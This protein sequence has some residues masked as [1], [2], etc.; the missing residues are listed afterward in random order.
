M[1]AWSTMD[2]KFAALVNKVE[3]Q[4][5][6]QVFIPQIIYIQLRKAPT[7]TTQKNNTFDF[8]TIGQHDFK[9]RDH[10]TRVNNSSSQSKL[11]CSC[12]LLI[13]V[14]RQLNLTETTVLWP[15]VWFVRCLKGLNGPVWWKFTAQIWCACT[16]RLDQLLHFLAHAIW[17]WCHKML[18]YS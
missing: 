17:Q 15:R 6:T 9:I 4:S 14:V 2:I 11:K 12:N 3:M 5:H 8:I 10:L 13:A 1:T 18:S 7:M 16:T